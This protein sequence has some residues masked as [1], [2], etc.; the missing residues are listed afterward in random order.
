M[1]ANSR[2]EPPWA[3]PSTAPTRALDA[4]ALHRLMALSRTRFAR[5]TLWILVFAG[6]LGYAQLFRATYVDDTYITLQ[7]ARN[8]AE[9]LTWGFLPGR[10][11]N[12]ATSPLN[13]LLLAG[14]DRLLPGA[15]VDAVAW[16]TAVEWTLMLAVLLRMSRRL[17]GGPHFGLIAF[18]GL[19]TNPLLLSAIGLEGYLYVLLLLVSLALFIERRWRSLGTALA[20]LTL[21]RPDGL[22]FAAL[23]ILL[24]LGGWRERAKVG[25]AFSLTALP[26]YLFSW[27]YLG[28]AI[29]DTL[30]IKLGQ[31][32][33][34]AT[35]FAD[36]L[37]LY[38]SRFPAAT[39]ASLWPVVLVPFA[40]LPV[41]RMDRAGQRA[42]AALV[43]YAAVHYAAYSAMGVPPYHWYYIHQIVAIVV[44]GALGAAALLG[45]LAASLSC[46]DRWTALAATV[47]L[48]IAGL[49]YVAWVDGWPAQEAPISSNW[50][51]PAQYRALGL[52][53]RGLV[54][55]T[56][57]V[58]LQGE[59]GTVAYYCECS[60]VDDFA[61][62]NR[63]NTMIDDLRA[64]KTGV[65]GLL[66]DVNFA[67]REREQPLPPP[68]YVLGFNPIS[69]GEVPPVAGPETVK[70]WDVSSH[71]IPHT[72]VTLAATAY[73]S[74][75][76]RVP[77][78]DGT[79]AP[80]EQQQITSGDYQILPLAGRPPSEQDASGRWVAN[81]PV[82]IPVAPYS[83]VIVRV[84]HPDYDS[85]ELT[86]VVRT[87]TTEVVLVL[88]PRAPPEAALRPAEQATVRRR[89]G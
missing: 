58:E 52:E 45:G 48:P 42:V 8:L 50:G 29:P 54:A 77:A 12:T 47:L 20:L 49:G 21:T 81:R 64:R 3:A 7:Y 34:G 88:K 83:T 41:W 1:E 59:I 35:T 56:D 79:V 57:I 85:V 72:Q 27:V 89:G 22:L 82:V 74:V 26:W 84:S 17:L 71:W 14:F 80:P 5:V 86:V 13:V 76:V 78:P 73:L 61:D 16:L 75:E 60:L 43:A 55:P 10:T 40:L 6:L 36:G 38:R 25:L 4:R 68:A 9:H 53:L 65:V 70:V 37:D 39:A 19:V 28:S 30:I 51:V 66:L 46:A 44:L 33:W 18:A 87:G 24:L 11:N 2:P 31:S 67:W 23:L 32:A 15:T 62:L 63:V 69:A